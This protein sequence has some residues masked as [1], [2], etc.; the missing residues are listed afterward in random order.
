M[1]TFESLIATLSSEPHV[2]GREFEDL[3]AWMLRH[4]P[5]YRAVVKRVWRWDEWPGRWGADCGIDLVVE[6]HSGELWAVQAKAYDSERFLRKA[7]LDSFLSESARPTFHY[8]LLI[9][10]TDL[11][12]SR[13]SSALDGQSVPVGRVMLAD[14]SEM[15]VS[16]P[17]SVRDLGG[18]PPQPRIT[19]R[20][21]S[22]R[23][24]QAVTKGFREHERGQL[25]MA[26]G[27]GK[28]L[29]GLWV[30]EREA[31]T[32]VLV[33]VPSLSLISQTM[34]EWTA[35][36]NTPR[37][38][39]VVCSD[40]SVASD[41]APVHTGDLGIPVTT[42]ARSVGD[43]LTSR[44]M[45]VVFAT[46]HS[47]PTLVAACRSEGHS[48][49][50]IIADEAHRCAGPASGLFGLATDSEALPGRRRLFMTATPRI[51]TS[52][53]RAEAAEADLDV[54]SM[55]DETRFGPV[56]H[57]LSFDD[58]VRENLL[59][60]YEVLITGVGDADVQAAIARRALVLPEGD[61]GKVTDARSLASLASIVRACE[62]YALRRVVTF[63]S[64]VKAARTFSQRLPVVAAWL[65]SPLLLTADYVSGE[66]PAGRRRTRLRRLAEGSADEP[67]VLANARCLTEGVNVPNLDAVAFIDPRES[68]T[69]I[70]QAVGR[71]MRLSDDKTLGRV[72]IP[73][74]L[75]DDGSAP[76]M[77][78][79]EFATVWRVLR[80][81]RS[82]DDSLADELDY[83][84]RELGRVGPGAGRLPRRITLDLPATCSPHFFQT[85]TLRVIETTA[86]SWEYMF[87]LL[88]RFS[89]REG[90]S[91]PPSRHV[92]SGSALGNWVGKQRTAYLGGTLP[93][94]RT[95]AL[96]SLRDWSWDP[97]EDRWV[98]MRA[99]LEAF[100]RRE[101]H[102]TPPTNSVEGNLPIGMWV[103]RQRVEQSK[104]RLS[105]AR[106]ASLEALSGWT[107]D[108]NVDRFAAGLS[109]LSRFYKE[110]GHAAVPQHL[111]YDN[112]A[113]GQWVLNQRKAF[114]AGS[115]FPADQAALESLDGWTWV[116]KGVVPANA[117]NAILAFV[118]REGH[119]QVPP[120]H[121][122]ANFALGTWVS[123][124]RRRFAR[125]TLSRGVIGFL[126]SFDGW[127]W[128]ERIRRTK[129][130]GTVSA[131]FLV[132]RDLL[133]RFAQKEG[134]ANPVLRHVEEGVNLGQWVVAQRSAYRRGQLGTAAVSALEAIPGWTW[135]PNAERFDAKCRDLATYQATFGDCYP[136]EESQWLT[137]HHWTNKQR[138]IYRDGRMLEE[139]R[140]RLEAVPGWTWDYRRP[141]R[142]AT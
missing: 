104:G 96:E 27:T 66:M 97:V 133:L 47:A 111:V 109:H 36:W 39:L 124:A 3:C 20:P 108:L 138:M 105:A 51:Y 94:K 65:D 75:P 37:D 14:L 13:A 88:Q 12:G 140:L 98:V 113:L 142:R 73:V 63:H 68:Q 107:W 53:L 4:A 38:I 64:R 57:R 55:D 25:L 118:S 123:G 29:V 69:D 102:A 101:G 86:E 26:C 141:R 52:R 59:T 81:L 23:A 8:R 84:R 10:T 126:E 121:V 9:A 82:H 136:S 18:E 115:L 128:D 117:S 77:D 41:S 71:V 46:Y 116:A 48:F 99:A 119:C 15:V 112:Y 31:A 2:R 6:A 44:P 78:S 61:D 76:A 28:T 60:D 33:L 5:L 106:Q 131:A 132:K 87:G 24:I 67:S 91:Q 85:L 120:G 35:N 34:H 21:A 40:V 110:H 11:I 30:A 139:R 62:R 122:E 42:D 80:A 130:D 1:A 54:L 103:S 100:A 135:D 90:H 70:V 74:F 56:F 127:Q 72:I 16:W 114:K 129:S 17:E 58:A 49:D 43:F 89:A 50:L 7:D 22:K 137:L 19:P 92:E 45:N 134:H 125:G 83:L 93:V 79:T 32:S 95:Q